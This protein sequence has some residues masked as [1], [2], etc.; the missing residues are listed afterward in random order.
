MSVFQSASNSQIQIHD[1]NNNC[2]P[3]REDG[4][5]SLTA[6]AKATGKKVS[7]YLQLDSSKTYHT[8][9]SSDA[10][11][12]ASQLIQV[13]KGQHADGR[14][15]G[16]WAHVEVAI[17]FAQWCSVEFRIWANRHLRGELQRIEAIRQDVI[18]L[19]LD[20]DLIVSDYGQKV[21]WS[22]QYRSNAVINGVRCPATVRVDLDSI[23][24]SRT[25][26]L[27]SVDSSEVVLEGKQDFDC[28]S[29]I[30]RV[31]EGMPLSTPMLEAGIPLC[32]KQAFVKW[33]D[34][35]GVDAP[36]TNAK[37]AINSNRNTR[38]LYDDDKKGFAAILKRCEDKGWLESVP[39][40]RADS[41]AFIITPLFV[42]EVMPTLPKKA[43]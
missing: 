17:D 16:T 18:D 42:K 7:H 28:T 1:Y 24:Y 30:F 25:G 32:V 8:A 41:M 12:P 19:D 22:A 2:I 37:L 27:L 3:Q 6:M 31:T 9:L 40:R 43:R 4:Y 26:F 10:G 34:L 11:I 20:D 38:K 39:T 13:V 29:T 21:S 14:E 23:P 33:G 36:F 5:V 35:R 15:Q